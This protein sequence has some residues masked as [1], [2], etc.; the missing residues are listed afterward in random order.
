MMTPEEHRKRHVELH[1]ALDE[2]WADYITH[3]P[4]EFRVSQMPLERLLTWSY[5]QTI[6]PTEYDRNRMN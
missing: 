5:E 4:Q 6:N 3:H 1:A 2:L